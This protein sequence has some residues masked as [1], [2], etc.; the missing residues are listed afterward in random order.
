MNS[1]DVAQIGNG[2]RLEIS[3]EGFNNRII[4]LDIY[5]E[6]GPIQS[7]GIQA[8]FD[9]YGSLRQTGSDNVVQYSQVGMN[10]RV[11]FEQNGNGNFARVIVTMG[12]NYQTQ[13]FR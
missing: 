12:G 10:S 4:G 8:G 1:T 6:Y 13:P 11:D 3:Q 5:N 7:T 2:N 9:N